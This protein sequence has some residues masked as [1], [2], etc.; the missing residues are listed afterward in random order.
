MHEIR[1]HKLIKL[2]YQQDLVNYSIVST[3]YLA[4]FIISV[5]NNIMYSNLIKTILYQ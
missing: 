2:K 3:L 5:H 1:D 4:M